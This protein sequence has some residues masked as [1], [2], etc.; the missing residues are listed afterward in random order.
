VDSAAITRCLQ[1]VT[2][3]TGELQVPVIFSVGADGRA[4]RYEAQW[5]PAL[6]PPVR[7]CVGAELGRAWFTC[8]LSGSARVA[9]KLH[10]EVQAR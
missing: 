1:A 5:P 4:T 10:L 7:E 8:P 3:P 2:E 9:A 6:S